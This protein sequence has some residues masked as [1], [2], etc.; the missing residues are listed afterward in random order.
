MYSNPQLEIYAD[1]VKCSHGSTTGQLDEDIL[2]YL[3]SRGLNINLS[4]TLLLKGFSAEIF[5]TIKN[6]SIKNSL[7]DKFD[8]WLNNSQVE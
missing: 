2:F 7:E 8:L 4:K 3:Q 1:D 5:D 6:N